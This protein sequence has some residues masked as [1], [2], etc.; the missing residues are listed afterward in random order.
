MNK[1]EEILVVLRGIEKL[2][3]DLNYCINDIEILDIMSR[4]YT[5]QSCLVNICWKMHGTRKIDDES[6]F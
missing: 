1:E 5:M 2:K 3:K 4:I 6:C